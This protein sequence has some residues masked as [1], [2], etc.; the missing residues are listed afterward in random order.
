MGICE[1]CKHLRAEFD[2]IYGC[3]DA[4]CAK[5][6]WEGL[7]GVPDGEDPQIGPEFCKDH[8]KIID[9]PCKLAGELEYRD[10]SK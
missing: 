3:M 4:W 8:E 10:E 9:K 1:T 5:R 6:H 2:D 7:G